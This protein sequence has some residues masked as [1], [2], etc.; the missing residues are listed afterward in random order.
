MGLFCEANSLSTPIFS[1][2]GALKVPSPAVNREKPPTLMLG[3]VMVIV[4][5]TVW[6]GSGFGGSKVTATSAP[7]LPP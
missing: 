3:P 4:N 6:P 1:P 5:V 7:S 2:L